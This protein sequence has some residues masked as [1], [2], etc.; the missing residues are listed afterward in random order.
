MER[1]ET[2]R[3][4]GGEQQVQIHLPPEVQRGV[5]A[6]QTHVGH[7]REEFILDFILTTPPAG[8][9]NAR[10]ILSPQHARRLL[11][12]LQDGIHRYEQQFGPIEQGER[13][14]PPPDPVRH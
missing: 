3:A 11:A 12:V 13:L 8:V 7:T 10:V 5:Y 1:D 6:N 9:V 14:I 2:Q 4:E